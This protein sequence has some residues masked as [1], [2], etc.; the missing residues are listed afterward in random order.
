MM[1]ETLIKLIKISIVLFL[2]DFIWINTVSGKM[3]TRMIENIQGS[4]V[5]IKIAGALAAYVAI[6]ALF[7][8]FVSDT[9]TNMKAF[10]LGFLA[11]AIYDFTSYALIDKWEWKTS[12]LDALW[13][14]ALFLLTKLIVYK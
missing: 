8:M 3:F 2:L 7:Y 13:G 11:Y 6:I 14:G 9:T 4:P 5:K 12:V 1:T 10:L